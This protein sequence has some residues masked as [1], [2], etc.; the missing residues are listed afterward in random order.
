MIFYVSLKKKFMKNESL[1]WE[2]PQLVIEEVF[3]TLGGGYTDN[4]ENDTYAPTSN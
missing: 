3:D 4:F 2:A 1:V